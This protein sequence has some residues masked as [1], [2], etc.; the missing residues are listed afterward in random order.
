VRHMEISSLTRLPRPAEGEDASI[1]LR[2]HPV[3]LLGPM[4][5]VL[6]A[7]V[8]SLVVTN[9]LKRSGW[10][11]FCWIAF[12]VFFTRLLWRTYYWFTEYY[13]ATTERVLRVSGTMRRKAESLPLSRVTDI[14]LYQS[15]L[16][17]TLGF[18]NLVFE[19]VCFDRFIWRFD[20]APYPHR[21][22]QE[23]RESAFPDQYHAGS[24][25]V[26]DAI[27]GQP[28]QAGHRPG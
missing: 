7:F 22:L 25:L 16:G 10:V 20:C 12:G 27:H 28:N 9:T 24:L 8:A 23:L 14:R 26:P 13:M 15:A 3:V 11:P 4:L 1:I 18:G 5:L 6:C 17:R 21:L 2:R 19:S